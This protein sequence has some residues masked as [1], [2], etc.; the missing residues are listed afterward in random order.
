[1][2]RAELIEKAEKSKYKLKARKI[3]D[4]KYVDVFETNELKKPGKNIAQIDFIIDIGG[5]SNEH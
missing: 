4:D 5:S 3:S 2:T 1:M